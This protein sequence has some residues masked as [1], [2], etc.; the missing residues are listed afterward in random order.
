MRLKGIAKDPMVRLIRGYRDGPGGCMN[1][2]GSAHPDG[3][4]Q[5]RVGGRM[6]L[7]HRLSA[8]AWLNFDLDSPL[9]VCHHCDNRRC[10]NPD[11]LFIGT[12]KDNM[13]DCAIKDRR[14]SM[15][16]ELNPA[17][18]LTWEDV[19]AIRDAF[20]AGS[21]QSHLAASYGVSRTLIC[22]IVRHKNWRTS[23]LTEA[24]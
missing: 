3:Y 8:S 22:D 10:I 12:Q 6:L 15:A 11:H 5:V 4:C 21:V 23:G 1:W 16:G 13:R 18:I 24:P 9:K 20:S 17:A 7:V 14:A 2:V 19:G